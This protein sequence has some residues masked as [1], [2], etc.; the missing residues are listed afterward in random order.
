MLETPPGLRVLH[1]RLRARVASLGVGGVWWPA[2]TDFE[3]I[4]GAILTQNTAWRNVEKALA[5]MRSRSLL[6]PGALLATADA[7]L[8]D[9]IR[10]AGF[11]TAKSRYLRAAAR[12]WVEEGSCPGY[13]QKLDD[14]QLRTRLLRIPGFGPETAD[15]I[16]LY[17]FDRP[18]FIWDA[19]ARRLLA[20]VGYDV[21]G[22]YEAARRAL[23]YLVDEAG[24]TVA[25]LAELHGLI[26]DS[27]KAGSRPVTVPP[28]PHS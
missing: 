19:Y 5:R 27:G 15:V 24:L 23:S 18:M 14:A 4:A 11:H 8:I 9:A 25:E 6:E 21:P 7:V 10:P 13:A 20:S 12:W 1:E 2:D 26:V 17:I 22:S 28:R 16:M 3:M